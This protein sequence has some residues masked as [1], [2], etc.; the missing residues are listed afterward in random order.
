M[1]KVPFHSRALV[2]STAVASLLIVRP[3]AGPLDRHLSKGLAHAKAREILVKLKRPL[4]NDERALLIHNLD[5]DEV[6]DLTAGLKRLRSRS[7]DVDQLESLLRFHGAVE[8]AEPNY[9]VHAA[10]EA[11]RTPADPQFGSLWGMP[12]IH[13]PAAWDVARGSRANVVGVVDTGIDYTHPDLA[14]NIWKA[15]AAFT[16]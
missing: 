8:Y 9:I 15:P 6:E 14:A 16:V 10:V 12:A 5:A 2:V 7:L 4:S 1:A 3:L 11:E 13:A